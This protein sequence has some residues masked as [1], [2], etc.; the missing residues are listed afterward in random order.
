MSDELVVVDG[1]R[2]KNWCASLAPY[3]NELR[4]VV[5]HPDCNCGTGALDVAHELHTPDLDDDESPDEWFCVS[6]G[7]LWPCEDFQRRTG[8]DLVEKSPSPQSSVSGE[9]RRG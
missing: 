9:R 6:C 4:E 3:F 1:V 2:H 7:G 5:G 8:R